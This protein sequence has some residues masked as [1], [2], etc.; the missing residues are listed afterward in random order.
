MLDAVLQRVYAARGLRGADA[1]D[2]RLSGLL[3]PQ[4]LSG[5]DHC[6]DLLAEAIAAQDPIILCGDYD[7]D[8]ATGTAVGVLGLKLLGA[9]Q[10]DYV[11]PNRFT[12]GYGLSPGLAE[13]AARRGARWLVTV[14][15]GISSIDGVRRA[16]ELGLRVIVTDHHVP[17]KEL[18]QADGIVNP[19]LPGVQFASRNLA[20]VGVM[21][22]LLSALRARLRDARW[23]GERPAPALAGLLDL[24][25]LG[26]VADL[27]PLDR[28]NRVLVSAGLARIRAGQAR[29]G[30]LAMLQVA[31]RDPAHLTA[32]DLGFVLGPRVNAA[33]RLDDI[34]AGIECLLA[35]D[36]AVALPM[37]QQLEQI[38]RERR[39]MTQRMTD[40]AEVLCAAVADDAG[41]LDRVGVVV[42]DEGWHEGIVGLVASRLKE[43]LHRPVIAFAPAQEPGVLKGSA[44][45]IEGLHLRDVLA[46]VD[47]RQPG[48]ILRFGG[49]AMAAGLSLHQG[50]LDDFAALF[51]AACIEHVP[52]AALE[53]IIETDGELTLSE[54]HVDTAQAL[55]A[56]GPWGQGFPE[57]SF[58]GCFEVVQVRTVGADGTHVKYRL[59]SPDGAVVD[60]I[61]FGGAERMVERG[62]VRVVYALSINR[63]RGNTQ[64]DLRVQWLE[65]A[66]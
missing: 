40:E 65:P 43:R 49:H 58:D 2:L 63:F 8:G 52:P 46:E 62:R 50:A 6:A 64:L 10:V 57:P 30:L 66:T 34:R 4:G 37:A 18:P 53:Q 19:Q 1:A 31:G 41:E 44:R 38:N 12:M 24:V 27:V 56:G 7:C 25:A 14:D 60:A 11:V 22:Y 26:T 33:G 45:S 21:F 54:L 59:R 20:G 28:N 47:A 23:W 16:R 51:D 55:E 13:E 48:L 35:H 17:G 15:N 61:H 29:P 3:P 39:S 32:S 42:F 9:G 36:A 5:L